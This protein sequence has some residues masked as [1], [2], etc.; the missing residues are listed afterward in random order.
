MSLI[1]IIAMG[2]VM[3]LGSAAISWATGAAAL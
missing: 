2:S 3:A 1:R